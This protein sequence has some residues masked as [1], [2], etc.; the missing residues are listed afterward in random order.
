MSKRVAAAEFKATC[1]ELMD[2][3]RET[4]V[5]YVITKH[6]T[7]VAKLVQYSAP[8]T[9]AFFGSMKGTVLE[10][11]RPFEPIDGDYDINGD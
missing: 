1:L 4:G 10:Y 2:H 9:Q 6:G 11:E 8:R 3:V 7:P 5:E